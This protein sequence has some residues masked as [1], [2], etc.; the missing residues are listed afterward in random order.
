M[1]KKIL[2]AV[3]ILAC[4]LQPSLAL[5]E[6]HGGGGHGGHGG[7][8]GGHG[9]TALGIVAVSVAGASLLYSAGMF[10]R[11]TPAGY[12]VVP[13]PMGAVVPALPPG[14]TVVYMGGVPYYYY[15]NA[16][17]AAAPNGYVVTAP[18]AIAAPMAA[19]PSVAPQVQAPAP[20]PIAQPSAAPAANEP[21]DAVETYIPNG[22][23]SFT[24]VTL[25]KTEKGFLGPQ[26]E[27]YADHPT[28]EQLKARYCKK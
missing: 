8:Y 12:V 13:A 18:P 26:G 25:R 19:A 22:N 3:L 20:A 9:S 10:Y 15:G 28:E 1:N 4:F 5:A 27:F 11:S 6:G 21:S 16:Y 24:V 23:G 17:Y 7:W 14:Y 2:V